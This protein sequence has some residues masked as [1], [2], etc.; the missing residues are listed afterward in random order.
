VEQN[1]KLPLEMNRRSNRPRQHSTA[2][3]LDLVGL[4]DFAGAYP[5][6]LSGGMQQRVAIA[7]ALAFDPALLLMD[8]PF[9]ALDE[10]T[11][12]SMR[13]EL[14]RI[15]ERAQKTVIFVT[16]SI[17][18]AIVLSDVVVVMSPRP[19]RLRGTVPIDLARPRTD[20]VERTPEFLAY[21]DRLRD[22]L[23]EEQ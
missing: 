1:I 9:G 13:Y 7:R 22:L 23:R 4:T 5:H 10:I 20:A 6:Q 15:W 2:D 18:E 11:R 8:E 3:L 17:A 14:L 16:H 12:Q 21:V 19:G